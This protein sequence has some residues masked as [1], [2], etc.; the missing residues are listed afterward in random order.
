MWQV[1]LFGKAFSTARKRS[2]PHCP[3]LKEFW[4]QHLSS[5]E[6]SESLRVASRF[7]TTGCW[8]PFQSHLLRLSSPF[9]GEDLT[10]LLALQAQ[11]PPC[12]SHPFR[13]SPGNNHLSS[14]GRGKFS[15]KKNHTFISQ[16]C[17]RKRR[18]AEGGRTAWEW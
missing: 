12:L 6:K 18:C 11:D 3:P 17:T 4:R 15:E 13:K 2:L 9:T 8:A 1:S 16:K 14:P 10:G 7:S 5:W